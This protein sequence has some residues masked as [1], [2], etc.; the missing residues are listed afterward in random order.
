MGTEAFKTFAG[1]LQGN[2]LSTYEPDIVMQLTIGQAIRKT[3]CNK[4]EIGNKESRCIALIIVTHLMFAD[5][6]DL[7]EEIEQAQSS[8]QRMTGEREK[9]RL[10]IN[11]KTS[12][13]KSCYQH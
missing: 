11:E 12:E 4:T 1:A 5:D 6:I 2:T 7:S 3:T 13:I 9:I 8:L 10:H